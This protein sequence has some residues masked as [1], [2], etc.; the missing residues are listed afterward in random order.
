MSFLTALSTTAEYGKWWIDETEPEVANLDMDADRV[1]AHCDVQM[2]DW[3]KPWGSATEMNL[4]MT[5]F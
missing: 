3:Y 2:K 1:Q 4:F 5:S